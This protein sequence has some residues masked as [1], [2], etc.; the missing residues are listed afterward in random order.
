MHESGSPL[1]QD[2]MREGALGP[3][4]A[5]GWR[6]REVAYP[7]TMSFRFAG[8]AAAWL[9]APGPAGV[10]WEIADCAI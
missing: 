4:L 2:A 8:L 9:T 6:V 3:G 1:G 7:K 10:K 5:A